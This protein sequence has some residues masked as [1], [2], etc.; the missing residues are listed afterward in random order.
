MSWLYVNKSFDNNISNVQSIDMFFYSNNSQQ[1]NP[2]ENVWKMS[3]YLQH[4]QWY[5]CC[6]D[7]HWIHT[8]KSSRNVINTW[9]FTVTSRV[10]SKIP[11]AEV[12]IWAC[13]GLWSFNTVGLSY[14]GYRTH[15]TSQLTEE[16]G[17]DTLMHLCWTP[18][19]Q[20]QSE[21][22]EAH[23]TCLRMS[24]LRRT[25]ASHTALCLSNKSSTHLAGGED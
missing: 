17:G 8:V 2:T 24:P 7:K 25:R 3:T 5:S 16:S 4:T 11:D 18:L 10:H 23:R 19:I 6:F 20:N 14:G 13:S 21:R 12:V 1:K 22:R 9:A 15:W